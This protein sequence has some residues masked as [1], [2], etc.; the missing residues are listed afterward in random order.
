MKTIAI[1]PTGDWCEVESEND[2]QFITVTNKQFAA[3]SSVDYTKNTI[4]EIDSSCTIDNINNI[5]GL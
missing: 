1:L 2:V 5:L 3:L 4:L